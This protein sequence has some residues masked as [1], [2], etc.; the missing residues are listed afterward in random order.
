[1]QRITVDVRVL[2]TNEENEDNWRCC[3][4]ENSLTE[5]HTQRQVIGMRMKNAIPIRQ[6]EEKEFHLV[7][8][9]FCFSAIQ[10]VA[11][12]KKVLSSC[13][14]HYSGMFSHWMRKIFS[15]RRIQ[16]YLI[17]EVRSFHFCSIL[18]FRFFLCVPFLLFI[19]AIECIYKCKLHVTIPFGLTFDWKLTVSTKITLNIIEFDGI[20]DRQ[21]VATHEI[22]KKKKKTKTNKQKTNEFLNSIEIGR[23][24]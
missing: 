3:D 13:F 5:T 16:F 12:K 22:H 24:K 9:W 23:E 21:N 20:G 17:L 11:W 8:R 4:E 7:R 15:P 2:R 10:S 6:N 1:M 19:N 14:F 18:E